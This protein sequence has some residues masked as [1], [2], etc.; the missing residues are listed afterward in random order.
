[1][2]DDFTAMSHET[3]GQCFCGPGA[4]C[5]GGSSC[6]GGC[7]WK[8][9]VRRCE[10]RDPHAAA[11]ARGSRCV[12]DDDGHEDHRDAFG[13]MFTTHDAEPTAWRDRHGDIWRL[14]ADGR[15]HSPETAPFTRE[16]VEKNWG[17]LV[18]VRHAPPLTEAEG[19]RMLLEAAVSAIEPCVA[20]RTA[21]WNTW[22][23]IASNPAFVRAIR[24]VHADEADDHA[25]AIAASRT[26]VAASITE[27]LSKVNDPDPQERPGLFELV[28][29]LQLARDM[30]EEPDTDARPSRCPGC[31]A[32]VPP[33]TGEGPLCGPLCL[34]LPGAIG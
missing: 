13:E 11:T 1:M 32:G 18:A 28:Q 30:L 19:R 10:A 27:L 5:N 24:A 7:G 21:A 4:H 26:A 12:L 20:N 6:Q 22:N 14:G 3:H 29:I 23:E 17:P 33:H 15:M 16:H 34:A 31:D 8:P 25:T 9:T 2:S